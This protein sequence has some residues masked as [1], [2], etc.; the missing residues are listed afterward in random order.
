MQAEHERTTAR[1]LVF[2]LAYPPMAVGSG[3]YAHRLATGLTGAGHQVMAVIV[4]QKVLGGM[5]RLL[6]DPRSVEEVAAA[7]VQALRP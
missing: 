6:D 1:V 5:L 3:L 2:A 4:A 7:A